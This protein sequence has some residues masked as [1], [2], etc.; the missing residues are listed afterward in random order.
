VPVNRVSGGKMLSRRTR[1]I[2]KRLG[3]ELRLATQSLRPSRPCPAST[4]TAHKLAGIL[5][6]PIEIRKP[7][8]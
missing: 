8:N 2:K 6:R 3:R 4:G 7:Y 1:K 5:F